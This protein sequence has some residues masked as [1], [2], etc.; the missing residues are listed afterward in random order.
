MILY[1]Y[2]R[3]SAAYRVRIALNLKGLEYQQIP[4]NLVSGEQREAEHLSRSTQ[5]LVPVL[6]DNGVQLTQSLAIC[7]YLDDAYAETTP[8][9]S[10]SPVLKARQRAFAQAIACDI[11][12]INNLRVLQYLTGEIGVS[13]EGKMQWYHH[14]IHK[15]F[16]ALEATLVARDEQTLFCFGNQPSLADICLVPQMFNANR[17]NLDLS[18][19]PT[20]VT[21]NERCVVLDAFA[22]AHPNLQPGA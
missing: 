16:A 9:L 11:H 1:D 22:K 10:N 3:S 5:G 17:F 14:W 2:C 7:E 18:A 20:L 8:L 21:I 15:T 4:V 13:D 6:E 12:P 19:Y